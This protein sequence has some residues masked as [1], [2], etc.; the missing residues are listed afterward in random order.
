MSVMISRIR[1]RTHTGMGNEIETASRF[2]P[3][4][5]KKEM[6]V[7]R[8]I[9]EFVNKRKI[10]HGVPLSAEEIAELRKVMLKTGLPPEVAYTKVDWFRLRKK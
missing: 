4:L 7:T 5:R 1:R 9:E 3:A 8:S 6:S 10:T 2:A